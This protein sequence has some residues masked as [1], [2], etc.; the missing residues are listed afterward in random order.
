MVNFGLAALLFPLGFHSHRNWSSFC[1]AF[2]SI[3]YV[4]SVGLIMQRVLWYIF[5]LF[6]YNEATK[7]QIVWKNVFLSQFNSVNVDNVYVQRLKNL[8]DKKMYCNC[9]SSD[10][11]SFPIAEF[12]NEKLK[13]TSDICYWGRQNWNFRPRYLHINYIS[14]RSNIE[15]T[16]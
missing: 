13:K 9:L 8:L 2:Q 6:K 16:V 10:S 11:K 7:H 1:C 12:K 4:Q 14:W 15:L 5:L 3:W